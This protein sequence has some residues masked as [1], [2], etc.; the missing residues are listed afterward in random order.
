[1]KNS[2]QQDIRSTKELANKKQPL[3]VVWRTLTMTATKQWS[4]TASHTMYYVECGV[5]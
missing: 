1:M 3:S 4:H 2:S 5:R